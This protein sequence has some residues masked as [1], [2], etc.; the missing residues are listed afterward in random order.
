[1]RESVERRVELRPPNPKH[2]HG[3][4]QNEHPD[5]VNDVG[6]DDGG[7]AA[8]NVDGA[9][10]EAADPAEDERLQLE[11]VA[12]GAEVVPAAEQERGRDRPAERHEARALFADGFGNQA[13]RLGAEPEENH[14]K[15][16]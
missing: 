14:A 15:R 10:D 9:K 13:K 4:L 8:K 7:E 5:V 1:M 16:D 6:P 2:P 11:I 12:E 3:A